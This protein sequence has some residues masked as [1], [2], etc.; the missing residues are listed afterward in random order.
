MRF[1]CLFF[2]GLK[3]AGLPLKSRPGF[4]LFENFYLLTAS[5]DKR[6][7]IASYNQELGTLERD[8]L[9]RPGGGLVY[10]KSKVEIDLAVIDER[11]NGLLIAKL[12]KVQNWLNQ[13]WLVTD[14]AINHDVGYLAL[15]IG[16]NWHLTSNTWEASFSLADGSN[17]DTAVS[18]KLIKE[19]ASFKL[20]SEYGDDVGPVEL[21]KSG[22]HGNRGTKL[23]SSGARIERFL[24]F[25]A[26]ARA[27]QDLGIKVALYCSAI[28]SL[29]STSNSEVV[30]QVAER[31]AL[32][33]DSGLSER[34]IVYRKVKQAYALRS[35]AVHG[36]AINEKALPKLSVASVDLDKICRQVAQ[37]FFT[38]PEF[39][40]MLSG[41]DESIDSFWIR[42]ILQ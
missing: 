4:E 41:N 20:K 7:L 34:E 1:D 37:K 25:T 27:T 26:G 22:F 42:K 38:D 6:D 5:K 35:K 30:H 29:F 8:F 23:D 11:V 36:A 18:N 24:Y 14:H 15:K 12:A 28:E 21:H 2:S 10:E 33:A 9:M 13:L 17:R 32:A 19:A 40:E 31:V 3:G 16:Q 39:R